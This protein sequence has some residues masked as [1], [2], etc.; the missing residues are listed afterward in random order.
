LVEINIFI[1]SYEWDILFTETPFKFN[2]FA[3]ELECTYIKTP[4]N[5]CFAN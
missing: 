3:V 4:F 2:K 5:V 1:L